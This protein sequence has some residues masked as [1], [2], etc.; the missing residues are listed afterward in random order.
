MSGAPRIGLVAAAMLAAIG[1]ALSA[2]AA[3]GARE[4]VDPCG[5]DAP[6]VTHDAW[7]EGRTAVGMDI[8]S[9]D[10]SA[11]PA[12]RPVTGLRAVIHLDQAL[13]VSGASL[14]YRV[15]FAT[16]RCSASIHVAVFP[17]PARDTDTYV[18]ARCDPG[19]G[20]CESLASQLMFASCTNHDEVYLKDPPGVATSVSG[21]AL[22]VQFDPNAVAAELPRGLVHDLSTPATLKW[23]GVQTMQHVGVHDVNSSSIGPGGDT[24][25]R[26]A[27][28]AL[29]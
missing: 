16:S 8:C 19:T 3:W 13:P 5:P 29:G 11:L 20:P 12:S 15:A 21:D 9:A 18:E 10:V 27:P 6:L 14:V 24:A 26:R 17:G 4:V 1:L 25:H 23:V 7:T 22:A 28:L 2:P